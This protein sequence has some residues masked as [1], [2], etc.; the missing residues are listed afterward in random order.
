MLMMSSFSTKLDA[1]LAECGMSFSQTLSFYVLVTLWFSSF[2]VPTQR[3]NQ[4]KREFF[5]TQK[6][7]GL[8]VE[9]S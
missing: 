5:F 7:I 1:C 9:K 3:H 8:E 4:S 6:R 2:K